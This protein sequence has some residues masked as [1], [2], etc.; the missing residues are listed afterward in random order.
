[1]NSVTPCGVKKEVAPGANRSDLK[2]AIIVRY[3]FGCETLISDRFFS[4]VRSPI[5][6][7]R[8]RSSGLL[9]GPCF[10]RYSTIAL[11]F[12]RPM[13][14][15]SADMVS[16]SAVL[17]STCPPKASMGKD[18]KTMAAVVTRIFIVGSLEFHGK[19]SL[20]DSAG[21]GCC[22]IGGVSIEMR[23][24]VGNAVLQQG[25]KLNARSGPLRFPISTAGTLPQQSLAR[26]STFL[27]L[28][29]RGGGSK[30]GQR[31]ANLCEC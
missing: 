6:L 27:A 11:A 5:P 4:T 13:P 12:E 24:A 9:N 1:M 23:L 29:P 18:N 22:Q 25:V 21:I 15:N 7:T 26:E 8:D 17:I 3:F 31:T 20:C 16:A 14:F 10:L 2:G 30:L 19:R 28:I